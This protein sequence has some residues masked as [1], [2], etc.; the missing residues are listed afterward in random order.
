[1]F[2]RAGGRVSDHLHKTLQTV[3]DSPTFTK[4]IEQ[5]D[6]PN[7]WG[8]PTYYNTIRF[9]HV[10]THTPTIVVASEHAETQTIVQ[11]RNETTNL[12]SAL[13]ATKRRTNGWPWSTAKNLRLQR[14]CLMTLIIG[15][16]YPP[17]RAYYLFSFAS[18]DFVSASLIRHILIVYDKIIE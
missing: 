8:A 13:V 18:E 6:A 2:A 3:S 12:K 16:S 14:I 4:Y 15:R 7:N 9:A 5:P 17:D 1:M 11:T 10:H